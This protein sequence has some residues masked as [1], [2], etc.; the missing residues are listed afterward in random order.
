MPAR[1]RRGERPT[2]RPR[3]ILALMHPDHVPA[4]SLDGQDPRD[5][6]RWRATFD[7][8]TSLRRRGH[9]VRV[10]GVQ[11]DLAPIREAVEEYRPH[12]VFNLLEEFHWNVLYDHN[13]V[14][15][16]ELLR[17][18]Y[19]GCSPRGLVLSRDKAVCKQLLS[20]HRIRVPAFHVFP[21][22]RRVRRP[23]RLAF[24]LF[25]KS[26]TEHASLGIA[27]ASLVES[28]AEL[29]ERVA[30]IHRTVGTDAIAEQFIPGREVYVGVV[31]NDRLQSFTPWELRAERQDPD[32]PLIA[33]AK[34]KHDI[35]YQE[36][37][38]VVLGEAEGLPP[39]VA[40]TIGRL[41]KRI[42]RI[43][44]LSGYARIDYRLDPAGRLYFLDAN[45]NPDIG[46]GE[47]LASSAKHD[48][49]SYTKLL[50]RLLALGMQRARTE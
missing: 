9:D 48:G 34:V 18:P 35:D 25:V 7:V 17:A 8:V 19:T 32:E 30:F 33:T 5:I 10:L 15:Y 28:D 43:L 6:A 40:A 27:K 22:G 4:D 3:R 31:G 26:L 1:R 46:E 24:P 41:S 2:A 16:L 12:V 14:A 42:Y 20:F 36:R 50:E 39:E 23:K 29:A 21:F 47:E 44:G 38:G 11:E 13:I 37:L 45:P 49:W